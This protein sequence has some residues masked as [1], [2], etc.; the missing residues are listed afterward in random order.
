M[1]SVK[2]LL[3]L[4]FVF[5]SVAACSD[6]QAGPGSAKSAGERHQGFGDF[7]YDNIYRYYGG[8][9]AVSEKNTVQRQQDRHVTERQ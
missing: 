7:G 9:S 8:L 6:L 2:R 3:A 1:C 4:A 5:A